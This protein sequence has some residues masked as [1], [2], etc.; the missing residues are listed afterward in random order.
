MP[1]RPTS[2]A[3]TCSRARACCA[4]SSCGMGRLVVVVVFVFV[5]FCFVLFCFVFFVFLCVFFFISSILSSFS[6]AQSLERRLDM[7]EILWSRPL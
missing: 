6:N 3:Y 7:T 2:L 5:L 1:R 4:C